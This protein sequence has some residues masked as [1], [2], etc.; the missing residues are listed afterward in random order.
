MYRSFHKTN[1]HTSSEFPKQRKSQ[2]AT[3]TQQQLYGKQQ[4]RFT[5]L[6]L[7]QL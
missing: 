6:A 3:A 5:L 7:G 1:V 4:Q 2:Q